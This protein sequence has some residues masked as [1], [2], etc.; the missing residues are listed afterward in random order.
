[1][2]FS[3][4]EA[5]F[6]ADQALSR[7]GRGVII[8]GVLG[9]GANIALSL[10]ASNGTGNG[11]EISSEL[12]AAQHGPAGLAVDSALGGLAALLTVGGSI[13]TRI[14]VFAGVTMGLAGGILA[15]RGI[16]HALNR[17]W[18]SDARSA[19][20]SQVARAQQFFAAHGADTSVVGHIP[21]TVDRTFHNA[22]FVPKDWRGERIYIGRYADGASFT[23]SPD[24]LFH[25]YG[26]RI[27]EHYAPKLQ[28]TGAGGAINEGLADTFA[29]CIDDANWTVGEG[30]G[31][32]I[33]NL[34]D[35]GSMS[36][37]TGSGRTP[38]PST[39]SEYVNT[40]A[41]RGGVHINATIVG[42]A[43]YLIGTAIGRDKL[44]DLYMHVLTSHAVDA[45]TD[46]QHLANAAGRAAADLWGASSPEHDA[47]TKAWTQTGYPPV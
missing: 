34:E 23:K 19:S 3:A 12:V 44:A 15:G 11:A 33:R 26:H 1:M 14:G 20:T 21:I 17:T 41:D 2:N 9:A 37:N 7:L 38:F 29:A 10:Q 8:G 28:P 40:T 18:Y 39:R 45:N 5:G 25:E 24:V 16:D 32:P 47:V 30:G 46:F 42:H 36:F 43:S 35:P 13:P 4:I 6:R 27:I 22:A 31:S